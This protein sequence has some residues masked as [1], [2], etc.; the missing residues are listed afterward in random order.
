MCC[1]YPNQW[2]FAIKGCNQRNP[3]TRL[4]F[5]AWNEIKFILHLPML[6]FQDVWRREVIVCFS[7]DIW[8][9]HHK[10]RWE[11]TGRSAHVQD[12]SHVSQT[13]PLINRPGSWDD[14]SQRNVSSPTVFFST[15]A[16]TYYWLFFCLLP[17]QFWVKNVV[18]DVHRVSNDLLDVCSKGC[19]TM[20][21]VGIW[22]GNCD[23]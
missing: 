4:A 23:Q 6:N 12:I 19:A 3:C 8:G 17:T 9:Y 18:L 21:S 20:T 2:G 22:L 11:R 10:V 1:R 15:Y 16:N 13:D 14:A 7:N 5:S